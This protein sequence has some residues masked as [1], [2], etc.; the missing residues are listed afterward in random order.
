M[1]YLKSH[2]NAWLKK[3]NDN[4][5][6]KWSHIVFGDVIWQKKKIFVFAFIIYFTISDATKNSLIQKQK[7]L[8]KIDGFFL[9]VSVFVQISMAMLIDR[10]KSSFKYDYFILILVWILRLNDI[11]SCIIN[12]YIVYFDNTLHSHYGAPLNIRQTKLLAE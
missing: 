1:S 4:N 2:K 11:F 5:N 10:L 9:F 12:Q 8:F 6:K 7:L 3:P